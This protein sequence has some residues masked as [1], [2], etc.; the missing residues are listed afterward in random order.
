MLRLD[1]VVATKDYVIAALIGTEKGNPWEKRFEFESHWGIFF[2]F[3]LFTECAN[4]CNKMQDEWNSSQKLIMI[5]SACYLTA[6]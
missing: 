4:N 5:K 3:G 6:K 2:S 1:I